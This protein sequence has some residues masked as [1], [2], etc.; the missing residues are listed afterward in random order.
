MY[1][2]ISFMWFYSCIMH[3]VGFIYVHLEKRKHQQYDFFS[4]FLVSFFL[5]FCYCL[6]VFSSISLSE[7]WDYLC[8]WLRCWCLKATI[9]CSL[10]LYFLRVFL[11]LSDI[12][13]FVI[14]VQCFL[15]GF[16][17]LS[18]CKS[19]HFKQDVHEFSISY[20]FFQYSS[21]RENVAVSFL[22][23]LY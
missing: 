18:L 15:Q 9:L 1:Y 5:L 14:I 13:S 17:L 12:L 20:H 6:K 10:I 2:N 4:F 11:F 8:F 7:K 21:R 16:I 23:Y 19:T 3:S 22:R